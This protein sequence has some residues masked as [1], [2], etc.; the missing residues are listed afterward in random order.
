M[1]TRTELASEIKKLDRTEI[2]ELIKE[3]AT[4]LDADII[5]TNAGTTAV[6]YV[7]RKLARMVKADFYVPA[8]WEPTNWDNCSLAHF[9]R[10]AVE[11]YTNDGRFWNAIIPTMKVVLVQED[12]NEAVSGLNK[13]QVE[14][15]LGAELIHAGKI[16]QEKGKLTAVFNKALVALEKHLNKTLT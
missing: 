13:A 7:M 4:Y 2:L 8:N 6:K 10:D 14:N 3:L 12:D 9:E 1:T 16:R 11:T 5:I 15:Y